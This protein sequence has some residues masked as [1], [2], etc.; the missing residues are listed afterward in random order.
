LLLLIP[1]VVSTLALVA[2]RRRRIKEKP[3]ARI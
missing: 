3:N 2:L 1:L